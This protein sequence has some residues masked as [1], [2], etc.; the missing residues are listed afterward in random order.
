MEAISIIYILVAA[1]GGIVAGK[2][3]IAKNN[4]KIV[5]DAQAEADKL[6]ADGKSQSETLKKEKLLEAK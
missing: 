2:F 3:I 5:D 6:I 4:N 1:I